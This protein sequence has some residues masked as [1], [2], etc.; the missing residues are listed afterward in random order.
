MIQ[1]KATVRKCLTFTDGD[2]ERAGVFCHETNGG[3]YLVM[4]AEP[5]K[6]RSMWEVPQSHVTE[7]WTET[8]VG[9]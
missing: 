6:P 4:V 2:R 1:E 7:R 9:K 8:V 3:S 5:G